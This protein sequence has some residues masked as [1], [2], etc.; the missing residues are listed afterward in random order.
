MQM[1]EQFDIS[2]LAWVKG[3]ID[4]TL[5]QARIALEAYVE[6]SGDEAQL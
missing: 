5:K 6:D 4:E 1:A 3:E 2:T